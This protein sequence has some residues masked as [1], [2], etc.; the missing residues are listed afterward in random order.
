MVLFDMQA[1]GPRAGL[2]N[3][4]AGRPGQ[5]PRGIEA[6]DEVNIA[7]IIHEAT[8][9][10]AYNSGFH[11]RFSDNP[12]WLAEG[13]AMFFEAPNR[14]AGDWKGIGE[15]NRP[16]LE[17]FRREF[18]V[19]SR[20]MDIQKLLRNDDLLRDKRT[21][22]VAYAESWA[23]TYFLMRTRS[24]QFFDYLKILA[25]KPPLDQDTPDQRLADFRTAFGEDMDKLAEEFVRY[26]RTVR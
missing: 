9:Q 4:A 11:R 22:L 10:L 3:V 8:H 16:R 7:T 26:M 21:A 24:N 15:V 25:K 18:I 19:G 23:L 13:M 2:G 6:F 17:L 14:R 20:P 5:G 1:D 12:L